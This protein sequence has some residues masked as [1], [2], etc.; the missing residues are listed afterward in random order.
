MRARGEFGL[1]E[2]F[3]DEGNDV[4]L[5]VEGGSREEASEG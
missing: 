4:L 3:L 5:V 1:G 2:G